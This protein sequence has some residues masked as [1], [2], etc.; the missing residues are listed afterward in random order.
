M[1]TFL[2]NFHQ[3]RK[4]SAKIASHQAELRSEVKFTDQKL[5]NISSLHTDYLNLDSRSGSS[6]NGERAHDVHT[7]CTFYG[8]KNHSAEKLF[9]RIIK[10]KEKVRVVDVSSNRNTERLPQ[11]CFRC[12]SEDHMIAKCRKP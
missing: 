9:K 8:G 10:E 12:G 11:K 5:L 1:H 4:Y 7:K 6:R 3:G 2:D